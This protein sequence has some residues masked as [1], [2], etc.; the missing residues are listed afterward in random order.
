MKRQPTEWEKIFANEG[1]DKGFFKIY[2]HPLQL[3]HKK[4]QKQN[5]TK[6][7]KNL[8]EY[9]NGHFSK[10]YIQIHQHTNNRIPLLVQW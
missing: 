4:K 10:E 7:V 3:N 6:K 9:L 8:A 1:T 5:K 2:K